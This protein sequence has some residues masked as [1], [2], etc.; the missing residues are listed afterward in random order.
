MLMVHVMNAT[1]TYLKMHKI[2]KPLKKQKMMEKAD[3]VLR[4]I[5]ISNKTNIN[6]T[7]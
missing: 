3:N 6:N 4:N 2:K 1:I 7:F 5:I